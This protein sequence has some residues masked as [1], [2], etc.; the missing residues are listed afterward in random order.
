M[1]PARSFGPALVSG[2]FSSYWVYVVG[3]IAGAF[4]AVGCA[5]VLR[6]RGGDAISYAAGSG[7]LDEGS[8]AAKQRLS[9]E[10]DR[11]E[12]MPPDITDSDTRRSNP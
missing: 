9:E 5:I 6:G 2:D 12:T 7:V 3:P 4:I 8:R 11:G 1:N 10:I